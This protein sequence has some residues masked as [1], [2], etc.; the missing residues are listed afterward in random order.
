VDFVR[1][2]PAAFPGGTAVPAAD[3]RRLTRVVLRGERV[4]DLADAVRAVRH[5]RS[6][7][8]RWIDRR[9]LAR[10]WRLLAV[11]TVAATV[12]L[13]VLAAPATTFALPGVAAML[14]AASWWARRVV[15]RQLLRSLRLNRAVARGEL[16]PA[17]PPVAAPALAERQVA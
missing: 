4:T 2:L 12:V 1:R 10:A 6:L 8:A 17:D 5:A 16:S 7:E 9:G 15:R 11:A 14:L 3:S 13:A